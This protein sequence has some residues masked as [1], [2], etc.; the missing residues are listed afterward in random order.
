ML[1]HYLKLRQNNLLSYR[2]LVYIVLC[3]TLLA[4]LSTAIQLFWDYRKDLGDIERGLQSIEAS[5]LDSLASSLWKLDKDQIGIQLDGIMK[6]QD[7]GYASITEI[8]ADSEEAIFFRGDTEAQMPIQRQFELYY[9][10]TLVGRLKV[11]ATLDNV[12]LRLIEKFFII[13]GSQTI[14]TFLV[15]I[16]I[17]LVVHYLVIT[18]LTSL[19]RYTRRI[20]LDNL[21]EEIS[22]E[23]SLLRRGGEDSLDQLAETLNQMRVN[24]RRQ[25]QAKKRAQ[26]Q[27][28]QLNE[29][30][31]QRVKYR[32]ATLKHTNDRLTEALDELTQT[33]DRLV[34]SEKMAALGELVSGIAQEIERPLNQG[35]DL[36]EQVINRLD[37]PRQIDNAGA[38][39]LCK[40]VDQVHDQLGKISELMKAFRLIAVDPAKLTPQRVKLAKLFANLE[41]Q[42]AERLL[43][44]HVRVEIDCDDN[45]EIISY[46]DSLRQIFS[47]LISNSLQHGFGPEHGR[48][49]A[50]ISIQASHHSDGVKISY[51]DNGIGIPEQVLPRVFEPFVA[52]RGERGGSGLGT[53]VV[54]RLVT[55]LLQGKVDCHNRRGEGVEFLIKV[56][57]RPHT[58][59][60]N[61]DDDDLW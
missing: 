2:L 40:Q 19:A 7:I 49:D 24:I 39:S 8:V 22:L 15:S 37:E 21:D 23:S 13:L 58:P 18:H 25:L 46:P 27:L 52:S 48:D 30:L 60:P 32:T 33:K 41:N 4:I 57:L 35:M 34:E 14:K 12:Y 36:S 10:D 50:L 17:L 45:L 44:Y 59:D 20:G 5:Y 26:Q 47:Q 53:H 51:R 56:P 54:Y 61:H 16:C 42:L 3:S 28:E 43:R 6:L 38:I 11:G 29:E 31:E 55:G 1:K 9:R